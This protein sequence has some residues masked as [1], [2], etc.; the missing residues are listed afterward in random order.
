M[1]DKCDWCRRPLTNRDWVK[2]GDTYVHEDCLDE[3][4]EYTD[5]MLDKRH[6]VSRHSHNHDVST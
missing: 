1:T 5:R 2:V 4:A 6:P 3:M